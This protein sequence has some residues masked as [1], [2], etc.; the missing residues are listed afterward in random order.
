MWELQVHIGL[1]RY[2]KDKI[3][4]LF[5]IKYYCCWWSFFDSSSLTSVIWI[6]AI[7]AAARRSRY[8]F[9]FLLH[10]ELMYLC[11]LMMVAFQY[12]NV[13]RVGTSIES[14]AQYTILMFSIPLHESRHLYPGITC[15]L[16][17]YSISPYAFPLLW[18]KRCHLLISAFLLSDVTCYVFLLGL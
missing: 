6:S 18:L 2:W 5:S 4:T 16:F 1:L 12:H 14:D 7:A 10:E 9:A 8:S 15:Q 3:T 13:I 17:Q 11:S